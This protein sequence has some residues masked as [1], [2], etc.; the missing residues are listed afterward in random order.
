MCNQ[1]LGIIESTQL[2]SKKWRNAHILPGFTLM[3]RLVVLSQVIPD[4]LVLKMHH[5]L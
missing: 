4:L 1:T 3:K 2:K 5:S